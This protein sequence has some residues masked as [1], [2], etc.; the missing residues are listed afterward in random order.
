MQYNKCS[1]TH[2]LLQSLTEA[3]QYVQHMLSTNACSRTEAEQY[4]TC[5]MYN[6]SSLLTHALT[7]A[8]Q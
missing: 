6:T 4:D 1:L 8:E 3:E 5:S 2:A 7:E